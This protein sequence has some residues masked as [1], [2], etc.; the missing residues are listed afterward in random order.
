MPNQ[1]PGR[2]TPSS[3][4]AVAARSR[5][6]SRRTARQHAQRHADAD[7]DQHRGQR[8]LDGRR[9]PLQDDVGHRP[10]M[11]EAHAEIAAD[12][13]AEEQEE[14]LGQRPVQAQLVAHLRLLL[15][16]GQGIAQHDLDRIARGQRHHRED[17]DADAEQ[18]RY[19]LQETLDEG[20]RAHRGRR[21]GDAAL[22]SAGDRGVVQLDDAARRG[23]P[24]L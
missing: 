14:A 22:A 19:Q 1:N 18:H 7:G 20:E 12:G 15:G 11:G 10:A 23:L 13:V 6:V 5:Q 4:P 3:A 16:R 21:C 2:E 9:H 17:D 24:S 8:Q